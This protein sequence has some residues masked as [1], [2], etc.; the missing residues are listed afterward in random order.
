MPA[1]VPAASLGSPLSQ[2]HPF[3]PHQLLFC[4][5]RAGSFPAFCACSFLPAKVRSII[6]TLPFLAVRSRV[7]Y[8]TWDFPLSMIS[9][10]TGILATLSNRLWE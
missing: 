1:L 10:R 3:E 6:L 9:R 7:L 2:P 5:L 4:S 8:V